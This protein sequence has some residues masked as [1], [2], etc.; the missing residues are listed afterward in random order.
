MSDEKIIIIILE[1]SHKINLN[2]KKKT[3]LITVLYLHNLTR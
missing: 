3:K 1:K 2:L